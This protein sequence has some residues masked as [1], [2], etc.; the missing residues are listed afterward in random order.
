MPRV[1]LTVDTSCP[2]CGGTGSREVYVP[3]VEERWSL[4]CSCLQP[5]RPRQEPQRP[6][7]GRRVDVER[8]L[9]AAQD[10]AQAERQRVRELEELLA[11]ERARK[12]PAPRTDP[13]IARA[14]LAY[15]AW[16]KLPP[17]RRQ[18]APVFLEEIIHGLAGPPPKLD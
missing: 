15:D 13:R 17:G 10:R 2:T 12:P 1:P 4:P 9:R 8:M 14:L 16:S 3:F 5:A 11:Q 7:P 18:T 6:G